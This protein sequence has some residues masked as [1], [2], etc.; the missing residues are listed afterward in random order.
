MFINRGE[1]WRAALFGR[2][3]EH[4]KYLKNDTA[5][6]LFLAVLQQKQDEKQRAQ[7]K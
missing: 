6:H 3:E 4:Y 1:Q 2:N 7:E 5:G